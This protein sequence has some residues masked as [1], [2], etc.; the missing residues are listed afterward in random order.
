[1]ADVN[2]LGTLIQSRFADGIEQTAIAFDE[3]TVTVKPEK[4]LEICRVLRDAPEFDFKLLVDV[5][6][7][8]YLHYGLADW[9]TE[10]TTETGFGRGVMPKL[11]REEGGKSNRFAVVYHLLSLSNNHRLRLRVNIPDGTELIVDSVMILWPSA[12]WFEREVFDLF[13]ILFKGH[14]DLRRLLTDYGFAG[15]P[16]RKDFPLI[17]KV[18]ARYDAKLKRV[19]YEPVSIVPRTLEPKVI[20]HDHRYLVEKGE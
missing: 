15:H 5:C 2:D 3:L 14:P 8:D 17:G 20:R 10:S 9:Q 12:N 11:V 16:F 6:G 19:I 1:M 4:L 7:V 13:G 18:E